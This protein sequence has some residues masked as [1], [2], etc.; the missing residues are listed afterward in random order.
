VRDG[1][2]RID[3]KRHLVGLAK[4][5]YF[6]DRLPGGDLVIGRLERGHGYTW[7]LEL[8]GEGL[9][10]DP[11]ERV[12]GDFVRSTGC[13]GAMEYCG[14]LYRRVHDTVAHAAP[15]GCHGE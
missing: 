2:G 14:V 9:H 15:G 4:L 5:R 6:G 7:L 3:E 12:D 11:S 8:G 10:V 1:G 13:C